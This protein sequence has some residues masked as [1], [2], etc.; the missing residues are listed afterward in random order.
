MPNGGQVAIE[1]KEMICPNCQ[2]SIRDDSNFCERC[3]VPLR[4]KGSYKASNAVVDP[5]RGRP[6]EKV[7]WAD[8]WRD[9]KP[10][11]FILSVLFLAMF[12]SI[13]YFIYARTASSFVV[14]VEKISKEEAFDLNVKNVLKVYCREFV[15]ECAER[16]KDQI[17]KEIRLVLPRILAPTKTLD[18]RITYR[19]ATRYPVQVNRFLYRTAPGPWRGEVGDTQNRYAPKL[20]RLRFAIETLRG[21][22]PFDT[23]LD[24]ADTLALVEN[25]G[26]IT[27]QPGEERAWNLAY[28][29]GSEFQIEY[30]QNGKLY[31]TPVLRPR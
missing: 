15:R 13:G 22:A 27:F 3:G 7:F 19:N 29:E 18:A 21:D 24:Y 14:N 10:G 11:L 6:W 28:T 8:M 30:L 17:E 20:N 9:N 23:K 25:H 4:T 5:P 1:Y 31:R 26:S 2:A 16:G 12:G